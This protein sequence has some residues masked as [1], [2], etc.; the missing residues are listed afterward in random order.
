M[1]DLRTVLPAVLVLLAATPAASWAVRRC[2][3]DSV[4]VG[5]VC[6]DKYEASVWSSTHVPTIAKL[7]A[8]KITAATQI[9][10]T[11]L[12]VASDDYS[13]NDTGAGCTGHYAASVPAM[14]SRYISWFQ[15]A[16]ACRNSGKRLPTNQ[17]WQLAAMGTPDPGTDNGTTDCAV[18]S[19]P[20]GPVSTGSRTGCV[21]DVGVYDMSGNLYEMVAEWVPASPNL[22]VGWSSILID[23]E[24]CLVGASEDFGPGVL[25]RGGFFD[26]GP[27]AGPLAVFT[28][29]PLQGQYWTGFR[30]ARDL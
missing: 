7:K 6:I 30:C 15:A 20:T 12:G 17:E 26:D 8:G 29:D 28:W 19:N 3:S 2:P 9:V 18:S 21:S 11:Q 27:A 1:K 13:C 23:D 10:G 14:P 24:M 22:C 4:R 16:A 25:M 5:A